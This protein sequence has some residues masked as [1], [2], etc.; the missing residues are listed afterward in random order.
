MVFTHTTRVLAPEIC[1]ALQFL[2]AQAQSVERKNLNLAVAGASPR[3]GKHFFLLLDLF[4]L[5]FRS[6]T[7]V[8]IFPVIYSRVGKDQELTK[9][10]N[11]SILD[12]FTRFLHNNRSSKQANSRKHY[13][14]QSEPSAGIGPATSSLL[15]ECSAPKLRRHVYTNEIKDASWLLLLFCG[16]GSSS[17]KI[18][19]S[20]LIECKFRETIGQ[21]GRAASSFTSFFDKGI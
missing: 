20:G 10:K 17:T 3:A 12:L 13:F 1:W 18:V 21:H 4:T 8:I 16:S 19:S 7:Q 9:V 14:D 15:S 11:K 2:A 6:S 5:P